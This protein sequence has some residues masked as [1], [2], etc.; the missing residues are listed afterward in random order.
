MAGG[1]QGCPPRRHILLDVVA[2]SGHQ[3]VPGVAAVRTGQ[4]TRGLAHTVDG[5]V[6]RPVSDGG[7]VTGGGQVAIG[8]LYLAGRHVHLL[9]VAEVVVGIRRALLERL[10]VPAVRAGGRAEP[11]GLGLFAHLERVDAGHDAGDLVVAVSTGHR[12]GLAELGYAIVVVVDVDGP[13]GEAGLTHVPDAVGIE[14]VELVA[15]LGGQVVELYAPLFEAVVIRVMFAEARVQD[16][17][18]GAAC[19]AIHAIGVVGLEERIRDPHD[20]I[21]FSA[22]GGQVVVQLE[23]VVL[24]SWDDSV[25]GA[26]VDLV[27]RG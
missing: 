22:P 15:G 23:P 9:I 6:D 11:V 17:V 10:L 7:L 13:A 26:G 25:G 16:D 27:D 2:R 12:A 14:V 4:L 21:P 3:F 1:G 24:I 20:Q 19:S 5:E 18:R 8:I